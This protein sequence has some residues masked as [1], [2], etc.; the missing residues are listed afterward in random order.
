ML[1]GGLDECGTGSCAGPIISVMAVFD[2][3]DKDKLP[4]GVK[5]SK[6]TTRAQRGILYPQ[7]LYLARDVGIGWAWPWEVDAGYTAALQECYSRAVNGINPIYTPD[8]LIVDGLNK[9][10]AWTKEQVVEPK[11]DRNHWQVS[12]ASIIGKVFRD[13]LMI[14]MGRRF[15]EYGFENHFGYGTQEHFDAVRKHG[16]LLD[17]KDHSKYIHRELYWRKFK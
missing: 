10:H 4:K 13:H 9:V 1:I 11:A 12:A 6:E 14:S 16:L 17:S 8:M 15:P 2:D 3:S 7:L 5:D